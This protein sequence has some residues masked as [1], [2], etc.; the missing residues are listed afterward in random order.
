VT[1]SQKTS[2]APLA[3]YNRRARSDYDRCWQKCYW[4][5]KKSD[6]ALFSQHTYLVF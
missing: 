5:S 6:D 2:R 1:V 3:C 4:E